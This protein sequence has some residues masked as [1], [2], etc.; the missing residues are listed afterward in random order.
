[1]I[2]NALEFRYMK[3]GALKLNSHFLG[4]QSEKKCMIDFIRHQ[5]Q[6]KNGFKR[7]SYERL[8]DELS[9]YA[10]CFPFISTQEVADWA[11]AC[12][13]NI[14]IHAY[15]ATYK[16]CVKHIATTT[17]H[18]I[19]L[20][21]FIKDNHCY[22]ITDGQLKILSTKANQEGVENL[23]KHMVDMKWRRRHEHFVV[24]NDMEEE[25]QLDVS[26]KIIVLPEDEKIESVIDRYIYGTNYFVEYLHFNNNGKLDGLL[27]H[28]GNM[29]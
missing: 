15:D 16:K 23:W 9:E 27:D 13:P 22:L 19:T 20:V 12:H 8:K 7:Y 21:F 28:L 11:H 18:D 1:M 14:S 29:F 25:A 24:I 2:H 5:C 10:T 17:H 26:N 4:K 3:V 6:N